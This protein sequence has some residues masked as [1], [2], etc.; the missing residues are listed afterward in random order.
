MLTKALAGVGNNTKE[1]MFRMNITLCLHR[2]ARP[3]EIEELPETWKCAPTGMAG[4]PVALIW[5]KGI[6]VVDSCKPCLAPGHQ[7]LYQGRPDL[8]I[9]TDCGKC[10][11]CLARA[12]IANRPNDRASFDASKKKAGVT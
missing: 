10:P 9:P 12:K 1:R 4:G 7:V 6:E 8:W 11:P 2:A 5:S 3:E